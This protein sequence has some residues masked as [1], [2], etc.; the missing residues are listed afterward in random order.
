V[1]HRS[2]TAGV[3]DQTVNSAIAVTH[4]CDILVTVSVTWQMLHSVCAV[5]NRQFQ[6][7]AWIAE[8]GG[9]K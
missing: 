8:E 1:Q 3:A 5:M 7:L 2:V 6:S 4:K 9:K